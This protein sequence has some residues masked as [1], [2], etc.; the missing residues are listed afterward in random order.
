MNTAKQSPAAAPRAWPASCNTIRERGNYDY[1]TKTRQPGRT[2]FL[3]GRPGTTER[4]RLGLSGQSP[5]RSVE[6][7]YDQF[8]AGPVDIKLK[9]Q[10]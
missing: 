8:W 2:C 6:L 4:D 3:Y 9:Q 10:L 1:R 7:N 5:V